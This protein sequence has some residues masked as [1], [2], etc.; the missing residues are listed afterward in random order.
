MSNENHVYEVKIDN[1]VR[2]YVEAESPAKARSIALEGLKVRR[3]NGG[4]IREL[5]ESG[6]TIKVA[7]RVEQPNLPLAT[8]DA[9]QT[10]EG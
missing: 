5:Y 9:P 3:L 2:A 6:Q 4:E 10:Q 8:G 7:G 1:S